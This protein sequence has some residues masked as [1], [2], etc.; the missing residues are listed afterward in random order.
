MLM[1]GRMPVT[2]LRADAARL[3][4]SFDHRPCEFWLELGLPAE[5]VSG[6]GAHVGAVQTQTDAA[7][8]RRNVVLGEVGVCVGG[9]ALGAV[10]AGLDAHNQRAGLDRRSLRMR[11]QQLL[12]VSHNSLPSMKSPFGLRG[13]DLGTGR[14]RR[15]Y[16]ALCLEDDASSLR[17]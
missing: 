2:L 6:G 5:D 10:E 9:A 1:V 15:P 4:A 3:S 11:R 14:A 17:V 12:S 8:H 7:D 13:L 16:S